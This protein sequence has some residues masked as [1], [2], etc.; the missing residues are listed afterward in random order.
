MMYNH[1][2]VLNHNLLFTS[3]LHSERMWVADESVLVL[4]GHAGTGVPDGRI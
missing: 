1:L 4:S 3:R 2:L